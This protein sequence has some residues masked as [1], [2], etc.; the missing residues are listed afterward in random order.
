MGTFICGF[1]CGFFF[2]CQNRTISP[3]DMPTISKAMVKNA[4]SKDGITKPAKTITQSNSFC[5]VKEH[6]P[7]KLVNYHIFTWKLDEFAKTQCVTQIISQINEIGHS[8]WYGLK[9][10]SPHPN[11]KQK[12]KK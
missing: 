4:V 5:K 11:P 2:K 9:L 7:E 1:I 3:K 6:C 8:L 12:E 10:T